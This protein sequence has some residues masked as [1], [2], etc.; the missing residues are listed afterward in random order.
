MPTVAI[1]DAAGAIGSVT[2]EV[3]DDAGRDLAL[4]DLGDAR[5]QRPR[6][7]ACA[8]T[9][10]SRATASQFCARRSSTPRP[11]RARRQ[12]RPASLYRSGRAAHV[13]FF[14]PSRQGV[15]ADP[16][17]ALYRA[18]RSAF[19]VGAKTCALSPPQGSL[20]PSGRAPS[21]PRRLCSGIAGT[22]WHCGRFC[23]PTSHRS[24]SISRKEFRKHFSA[25]KN[26]AL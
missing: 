20:A 22:R 7:G 10:P 6:S 17:D 4:I 12:G 2:A 23:E 13:P 16:K 5:S 19:A 14:E 25:S 24:L 18:H 8:D 3:F 15:A 26:R 21:M 1:T 11:V 9:L